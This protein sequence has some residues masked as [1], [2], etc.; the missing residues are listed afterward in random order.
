VRGERIAVYG[1]ERSVYKGKRIRLK[2]MREP[3]AQGNDQRDKGERTSVYRGERSSV[4]KV[5]WSTGSKYSRGSRSKSLWIVK[6]TISCAL[7][8]HNLE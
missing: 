2:G 6:V 1:G 8:Y 3:R 4:Y 5:E 7:S